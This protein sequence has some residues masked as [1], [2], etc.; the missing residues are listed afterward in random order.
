MKNLEIAAIFYAMA[1]ILELQNVEWKPNAYRKA[2]RSIESLSEPI[3]EI[4]K[5]GGI[6]AL[7]EIP[8]IGEAIAKKTEE[9]LLTGKVMEYERLKKK[10]PKGLKEIMELQGLGPKKAIR[11]Y[12]ELKIDSIDALEKAAREGKIAKLEGFGEKSEKNI[13]KSI[14]MIKKGKERVL[15]GVALPIAREIVQEL[16]KVKGVKRIEIAGSLRRMAETVG[17]ID[18]LAE[19]EGSSRE[20]MDKFVSLPDVVDTLAKGEK[21]SMVMIRKGSYEIQVDLRI[22]ESN[23]FGAALQY[24]TGNKEHNIE[25]RKIAIAKGMKLN[26]YGLFKGEKQIAGKNEEEVYSA[27]GMK[28][29]PPELR[30][31]NGEIQAA[32]TNK[33]PKLIE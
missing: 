27:L 11:L 33:L 8:G 24:F 19:I 1:D 4:Y 6:K 29:I 31:N 26:E 25:L 22:I 15:I 2:A 7:M 20:I 18:I 13:I 30:E 16:K 21:K 12:K 28:W 14:E 10:I 3:E 32:M 9:Y 17:D 23:S 5:R